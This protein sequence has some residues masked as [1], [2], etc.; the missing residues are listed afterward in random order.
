[1][2]L[3]TKWELMSRQLL[4]TAAVFRTEK[5][6]ARTQNP[7]DPNDLLVLDG[8]QLVQGVELGLAGSLTS[9]WDIFTGYTFLDSEIEKSKDPAELGN[10]LPNTPKHSFNIWSTYQVTP[11]LQIGG[12]ALYV[13]DRYSNTSNIREAPDYTVYE[14]MAGYQ[15]NRNLDLRLNVQNL[16]DKKYIDFVGGGHFI[17]GVGRT[18]LLTTSVRF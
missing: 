18:V 11:K 4:L 5:T 13:G 9:R 1:M 10:E 6:N 8:E 12:G 15:V 16:T 14:A 7:D 2:E 3:G 17:P